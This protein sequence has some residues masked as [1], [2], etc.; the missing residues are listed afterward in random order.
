MRWNQ[1]TRL[2]FKNM[3]KKHATLSLII[4]AAVCLGLNSQE[5]SPTILPV[6]QIK[7][8]MTGKG[9]T[10][11]QGTTIDEFDVEILG[12]LRNFQPDR[13]LIIARLEGEI[14][15]KAGV[16]DGMS[17]SPVY[18]DGKLVGAVSYSIATFAKE[19]I[20]GITPIGE[21]LK[22]EEKMLPR[23]SFSPPI[24]VKKYLSLDEIFELNKDFFRV[25]SP[26]AVEGRTLTPL[27]I[28][29]VFSGFS[30][31]VFEKAKPYFTKIG[32]L[33]LIAGPSGQSP[34]KITIFDIRLSAGD[35]VSVQL[36]TGDMDMSAVG[37]VTHV[38]GDKVLAFGHP[39]YNLGS[40]DYVMSKAKVMA[41]VPSLERSFKLTATDIP[42]GRFSQD[43]NSGVLGELGKDPRLI[44]FTIQLLNGSS[45]REIK[46]NIVDDK[47]LTPALV[48]LVVA[49]ALYVEERAI[50]DL[51]L[52][53]R[54]T[55]FLENGQNIP[56]ED[57]FSGQNDTSASSLS[58]LL[59]SVVYFLSNN[60][61]RDLAIHKIDLAIR[62]YE[63]VRVAYLE[64]V[65]VDKYDVSP[66]ERIQIKL[67]TRNYRGQ[68]M[69]QEGLSVAAPHLPSGSEFQLIVADSES[70][71]QI[72]LG[73]YRTQAF[74]PR[75]LNQLIRLL[76]NL[77]KNNRIYFKIIGPKPGLFLKGEEMPNLPPTLK[78]MF[79]SSRAA[80]SIPT[81]LKT[82]TL[83]QYQI[84][85]PF[86]FQGLA[87]IPI[88][89]K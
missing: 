54:G 12:V 19:A 1:S 53:F 48:N 80:S 55:V 34:D 63:E 29:L 67:Y 45:D 11:F 73:Q 14:L 2:E 52:D 50:G 31:Q 46:V 71:R 17:G 58:N 16:I 21:M 69:L 66:G 76:G 84:P 62:S 28:P 70:L 38:D 32:F 85:V 68:S 42:V 26:Q 60:E 24:P 88:K 81:E 51:S 3:M 8:G 82:S 75:N 44:P 78:S 61:F 10:V 47:I 27:S 86:V 49:N 13:D 74:M 43:R 33:P 79:S 64:K 36:I 25:N 18:V 39:L 6:D 83:G 87:V 4:F 5:P 56:L 9:R 77:R 30:S 35:P 72:E 20:S 15:E 57:F 59:A 23:S 89:I 37:T 40:V 65:W 41:V 22:I 7:T